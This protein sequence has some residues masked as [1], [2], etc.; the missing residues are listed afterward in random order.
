MKFIEYSGL[1]IVLSGWDCYGSSMAEKN[2]MISNIKKANNIK[3]AVYVGDTLHD[4]ESAELS[5]TD[6]IQVNY[7]FGNPIKNVISFSTFKALHLHLMKQQK[8]H[9]IINVRTN[10]ERQLPSKP[11]HPDSS[12]IY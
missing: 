4:K 11:N 12:I 3:R 6:F 8:T 9:M 5:D 1:S 10:A 2:V 7:G